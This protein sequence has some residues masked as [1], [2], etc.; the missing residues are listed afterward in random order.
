MYFDL[1]PMGDAVARRISPDRKYLTSL[2]HHPAV[3][4]DPPR[5]E[6]RLTSAFAGD[7]MR[8]IDATRVVSLRAR[9]VLEPLLGPMDV[10][11]WLP[12]IVRTV[13]DV[14]LDCWVMHFPEPPDIYDAAR[15]VIGPS[16]LPTQPVI[17]ATKVAGHEII[18]PRS[19]SRTFVSDKVLA[20][21]RASGLNG[22]EILGS[23]T[24]V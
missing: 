3:V 6:W 12:A 19:Q 15:S 11:Q 13:A 17:S 8:V 4:T 23:H 21:M 7:W 5:M 20:A 9:D 14:P 22:Y 10:V 16:G 1:I 24:P 18:G 2:R